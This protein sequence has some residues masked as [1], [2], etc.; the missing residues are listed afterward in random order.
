M[1][2]RFSAVLTCG[3]ARWM[4]LA[5]LCG[6]VFIGMAGASSGA[7]AWEDSRDW[8]GPNG[9]TAHWRGE[10]GPNHYHGEGNVTGPDGRHYERETN[11]VRGPRGVY[12][13]RRWEG[14]NGGTAYS[15][16]WYRRW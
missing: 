6:G 15:G 11:V 12:A 1:M 13:G 3:T 8:T 2:E 10:G 7:M 4:K 5:V 9:G 16:R 14:P